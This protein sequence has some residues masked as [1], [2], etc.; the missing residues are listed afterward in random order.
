MPLGRLDADR[1]P[2]ETE[3]K[4]FQPA[5][6]KMASRAAQTT[7]EGHD[8]QNADTGAPVDAPDVLTTDNP[9][10]ASGNVFSKGT[11]SAK[12]RVVKVQLAAPSRGASFG[13][14]SGSAAASSE[15]KQALGAWY[16]RIRAQLARS[17]MQSYPLRA[18]KLGQQGTS[19]V[20]V[21]ISATGRLVGATLAES[22]GYAL[23]DQAALSGLARVAAVD[24]PPTGTG[25]TAVIVPVTFHL[26]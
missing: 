8:S 6:S 14:E 25:E 2:A 9:Y 17:G 22:S 10:A 26:N 21:K 13:V 24:A 7:R 12:S 19:R 11:S 16:D 3:S 18:R 4:D 20:M 23:L 1:S 5:N 15:A